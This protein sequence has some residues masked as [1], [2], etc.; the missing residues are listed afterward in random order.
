MTIELP[1]RSPIMQGSTEQH[2]LKLITQLCGAITPAAWPGVEKLELY[3][4]MEWPKE[5]RRRPRE[6]G[7]RERGEREG[8]LE[9][10]VA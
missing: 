9:P 2:Q 5:A 3:N 8:L 1:P 10:I 7:E 4:R 6:R